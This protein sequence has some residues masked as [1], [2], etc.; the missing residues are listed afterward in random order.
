MLARL[1]LLVA[2]LRRRRGFEADLDTELGFHLA[3]R[4]DDLARRGLSREAARRQARIELGGA[5]RFKDECR[6]AV[7]LRV[8]DELSADLRYAWRGL[9]RDRGFTAIAVTVLG[10]TIGANT[11]LFTFLHAFFLKPLPIAAADR[12]VEL[13][14]QTPAIS[15][16]GWSLEEIE[17]MRAAGAGVIEQGYANGT[18]RPTLIADEPLPLYA[19][20]V[21]ASFFTLAEPR[22]ARGRGLDASA[23]WKGSPNPVVVLSYPGWRR[24]TASDPAIVGKTLPLD[25]KL[26]TVAGVTDESFP[27]FDLVIPD[28]WM[29]ASAAEQVLARKTPNQTGAAQSGFYNFSALLKPG[30]SREQAADVLTRALAQVPTRDPALRDAR[31]RVRSRTTLFRESDEASPLALALLAAFGATVLIAAANLTNMQLAR[32]AARARDVAL[33]VS[34]GATRGR[35]VRQILSESLLVAALGGM[36]GYVLAWLTIGSLHAFVFKLLADAGMAVSPVDIDWRAFIFTLGLALAVGCTTGLAP[37]LEA[38]R[39]D[40]RQHLA[41]GAGA[42]AGGVRPRRLRDALLVTQVAASFVLLVAAG[43]ML[44]TASRTEGVAVGRQLERLVDLRFDGPTRGLMDRL[45]ALPGVEGVAAVD[46]APLS[47]ALPRATVQVGGQQRRVGVNLVDERFLPLMDTPIRRGR[48]FTASDATSRART[49]VVSEATARTLWPGR[50]PLGQTLTFTESPDGDPTSA[51]AYEVVGVAGDV[52]SGLFFQGLDATHVYVPAAVGSPGMADL[53]VRLRGDA[54]GARQALRGACREL[55]PAGCRPASLREMLAASRTPFT[56]AAR[57]ASSLGGLALGLACLGL[58]GLVSFGVVQRTR[59]IGV[60]M[61]LGATRQAVATEVVTH[62]IRRVGLGLALGLP[63]GLALSGGVAA[64]ILD[65][66]AFDPRLYLAI[67]GGL[68][69]A[70]AAAAAI[71]A[72]RASRIDPMIALRHE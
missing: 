2:R 54:T 49:I 21:T 71:P 7:G 19:E 36:A 11:A 53:M 29:T 46:N 57:I 45:A 50:D 33:R 27:G 55:A 64:F 67:A 17:V 52:V 51:G 22:F 32:G 28:L 70:A 39:P 65:A 66:G 61:A 35:L 3:A 14:R 72:R 25:G 60:R 40:L 56:V 37:A 24:L 30:V 41:E 20:A 23:D 5:E 48:G 13:S 34:L 26:F 68:L 63:L 18:R 69:L 44:Q 43:L 8:A 1:Q 6:Q 12:H 38:T 10:L 59:E 62:A 16:A 15:S 42:A 47:G 4:E 31:V 58:Y 9:R